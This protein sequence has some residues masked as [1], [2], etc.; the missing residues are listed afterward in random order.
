MI[1]ITILGL[2]GQ[3]E[4]LD[5]LPNAHQ[6]KGHSEIRGKHVKTV[7]ASLLVDAYI[8]LIYFDI[9]TNNV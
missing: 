9:T 3:I 8:N 6:S 4:T 5:L 2:H 7:D 1:A